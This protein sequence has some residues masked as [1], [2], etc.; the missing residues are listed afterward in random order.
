MEAHPLL[1]LNANEI[2]RTAS[3]VRQLHRGQALVFKAITLKEPPKSLILKYYKARE[4]G[5]P[6]PAVPRVA[7]AAYYLRGT[8]CSNPTLSLNWC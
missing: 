2:K 4:N 1:D 8:V 6:T 5:G 3:L 7:F